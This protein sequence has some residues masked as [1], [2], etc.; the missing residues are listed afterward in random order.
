MNN[1][2]AWNEI[3]ELAVKQKGLP[4]VYVSNNLNFDDNDK[5]IWDFITDKVRELY[6]SRIIQEYIGNIIH[7][8]L[9][10]FHTEIERD[11]FCTIFESPLVYSSGVY[12]CTFDASGNC[13]TENT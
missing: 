9:F 8:G 7:G 2:A 13:L 5:D 4:A 6:S 12:V 1:Y 10:F 3:L 11:R